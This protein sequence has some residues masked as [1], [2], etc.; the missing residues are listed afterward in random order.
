MPTAVPTS[1]PTNTPLPATNTP[2]PTPTLLPVT[3]QLYGSCFGPNNGNGY[4]QA[5]SFTGGTGTYRGIKIGTSLSIAQNA[6]EISLYPGQNYYTY[7]GIQDGYMYVILVDSAGTQSAAKY[8]YIQCAANSTPVPTITNTPTPYPTNYPTP[9]TYTPPTP[10]PGPFN[11]TISYGSTTTNACSYATV[12]ANVSGNTSSFCTSTQLYATEFASL[13][14]GTYYF[15]NGGKTLV[16]SVTNTSPYVSVISACSDCPAA[17]ATPI[18]TATPAPATVT[19][20]PAPATATPLP[21]ATPTPA[22]ATA[23]PTPAPATS[24]P[25]P[26]ATPTPAP[27]TSTPTPSPTPCPCYCGANIVN[28]AGTTIT[29][30]YQN[31]LNQTISITLASGVTMV[32]PCGVEGMS[33]S[34]IK[35][36]SITLSGSYTVTYGSCVSSQP[37]ATAT[38]TP[39]NTPI[40]ITQAPT[41]TNTPTPSPTPSGVAVTVQLG[42]TVGLCGA[43]PVTRYT[44]D[45]T[46]VPGRTVYMDAYLTSVQQTY[47]YVADYL[48][49][50]I[51]NLNSGNGIV[52]TQTLYNC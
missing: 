2:T 41:I 44:T 13:A 6:S 51:Y 7:N 52:G 8:V 17:T 43:T 23:T 49:G 38:P 40:P 34:Y 11:G 14:T 26:S 9:T 5:T 29:G 1:T 37:A 42:L 21:T 30:S 45:G 3:F 28:T 31:C 36:G 25:T 15:S 46:I 12:V 16:V 32:L 48:Y 18:P 24:T 20:T 50:T 39:T 4:F 22:P 10:T 19:P 47:N 27:A 33:N 35:P